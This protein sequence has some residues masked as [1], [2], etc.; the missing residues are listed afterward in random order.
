MENI[1]ILI[2]DDEPGMRMA[3]V[4]TLRDY[5]VKLPDVEVEVSFTIDEASSGEEA[6]EKINTIHP[7]ILLL[8]YKLPGMSGLEVLE[9]IEPRKNE[10]LTIMITAYASLETAITATKRGAYDFLPKPFTPEELKHVIRKTA[11]RFI[12]ISQARKLAEEKRKVRFQFISVLAHE[13]KAPLAAIEGY[14]QIMKSHTVGDNITGYDQV[15]DR[16]MVRLDGMRKL[17]VDLLDMTRIESGEKQRE[18]TEID[19]RDVAR[20]AMETVLPQAS[21]RS[22]TIALHADKPV[23]MMADRGEIEII[24][25]NLVSNAVKYNRDN[26]KVDITITGR[27][28]TVT[29]IVADTGIGLTKDEADK[30]FNDFVRIKNEKTRTILGSGLGLSIVKKLALLYNGDAVVSSEPDVGS[31][32]TVTLRKG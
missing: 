20:T 23:T 13:L 25:N 24:L 6:L 19:I 11:G 9:K 16:S 15:I 27:N 8:D 26:G 7:H 17:I 12:L 10:L 18:L 31:T 1:R 2:T 30:L 28:G 29:I 4:R 32:F 21:E 5:K 14:L 22:V 3:V